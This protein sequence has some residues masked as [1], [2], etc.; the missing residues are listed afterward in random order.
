VHSALLQLTRIPHLGRPSLSPGVRILSLVKWHR[1]IV[2]ELL[3]NCIY[4]VSIKHTRQDE[5]L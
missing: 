3:E 1:R 4:L 2:Y 5:N